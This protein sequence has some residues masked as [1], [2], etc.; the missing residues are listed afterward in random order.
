MKKGKSKNLSC[1]LNEMVVF[2]TWSEYMTFS[3][4]LEKSLTKGLETSR[5]LFGRAKDRAKDL[6]EMGILKY[7]VKQLENQ[8]EKLLGRL[9]TVVFD[10]VHTKEA[11]SIDLSDSKVKN[12]LSEIEDV[13]TRIEEKEDKYSEYKNKNR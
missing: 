10:L 7:E 8:A 3:E 5:E 2:Y 1:I 6:S 9:G 12:L 4:R 13:K 11:T